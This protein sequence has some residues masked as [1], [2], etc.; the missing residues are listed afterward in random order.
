[1]KGTRHILL[2]ADAADAEEPGD[3]K[4]L[5]DTLDQA[6]VTVSV[7][8][9]GAESDSDAEFLKD[10]AA[11]GKGRI[12]FT[13][14]VNE[15]PRLFAQEAI[16]VARSSFVTEPAPSHVLRDMVLL[17]DL[18]AS[19]FPNVDGFNLTY[20]RPGATMAVV[21]TTTITLRSW[22]SGSADSGGLP[23]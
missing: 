12:Q 10:I 9:L 13:T 3:Y 6:G 8:G 16:T 23:R 5:L 21:T 19:R 1:N 22:P 2:F 11:R 7:I 17:G 14:D 20:L 15:L 18:P 4:R